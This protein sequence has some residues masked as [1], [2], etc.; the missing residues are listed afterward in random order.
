MK[1]LKRIL[2]I[3]AYV[4]TGIF[5]LAIIIAGFTQTKFFKDRL[6]VILVSE[7]ST[8][9]NGSLYLGTI[10]GNFI[11]GFTVDSAAIYSGEDHFFSSGKIVVRYDPFTL[12]RQI[13]TIKNIIIE[14]PTIN[15][16]RKEGRGWNTGRLFRPSSDTSSGEFKWKIILEDLEL[17]NASISLVDSEAIIAEYHSPLL[18]GEVEY[19]NFTL[20][21]LNLKMRAQLVRDNYSATIEHLSF[22]SEKPEFQLTHFTGS[23]L[24]TDKGLSAKNMI[25]QTGHSYIEID[26]KLRGVNIFEG[27]DLPMLRNDSTELRF[28]GKNIDFNELKSFLPPVAFLEGAAS[29][30]LDVEGKFGDLAI[31]RLNVRTLSTSLNL[32]GKFQNLHDPKNLSMD[33]FIGDSKIKP[34]DAAA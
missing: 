29:V 3:L 25:I 30:D 13:L 9:I 10:R 23:Y 32:A 15:F 22:Y 19:H 24:L 26:A 11:T 34:S 7:I 12:T 6:R 31:Q 14:R 4:V 21:D 8:Q 28:S 1:A 20:K 17:K 33:I 27:I 18:A 2:K 16:S 5:L